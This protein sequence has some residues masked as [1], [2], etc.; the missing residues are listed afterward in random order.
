MPITKYAHTR[1]LSSNRD[2]CAHISNVLIPFISHTAVALL[3][4]EQ[5]P[6][7]VITTVRFGYITFT[8]HA[9]INSLQHY[10]E[11]PDINPLTMRKDPQ[12]DCGEMTFN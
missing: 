8:Q 3:P 12:F 1:L 4:V 7:G 9:L 11:M 5:K 6:C 2:H 10:R